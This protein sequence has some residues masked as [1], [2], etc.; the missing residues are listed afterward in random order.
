MSNSLSSGCDA[1]GASWY[2]LYLYAADGQ[3]DAGATTNNTNS[4]DSAPIGLLTG[5][6]LF[7]T[8]TSRGIGAAAIRRRPLRRRAAAQSKMAQSTA[9][10]RAAPA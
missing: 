8:G 4:N 5:K 10:I 2:S 6:V 1:D 7:I 3:P 9:S